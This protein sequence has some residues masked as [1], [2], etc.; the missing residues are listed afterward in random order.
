MRASALTEPLT[1]ALEHQSHR[2]RY[3]AQLREVARRHDA[4]VQ[5]RQQ[6]RLRLHLVRAV[7]QVFQR[8]GKPERAER[9]A[10]ARVAQLRL[11]PEGEEGFLAAGPGAGAG[12]VE[13]LLEAQV[14]LR[15]RA[16]RLREGAV[17]A[18]VATQLRQRDEYLARVGD[19]ASVAGEREGLGRRQQLLQGRVRQGEGGVRLGC[20]ARE[21]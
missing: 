16:R 19:R 9:P 2:D 7:R 13:H 18:H 6:T 12:D 8:A 15:Q 14:G 10:R 11:V 20:V 17:V 21:R 4:R 3:R 1:G 5:V